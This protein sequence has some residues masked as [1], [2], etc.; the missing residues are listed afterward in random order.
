MSAGPAPCA[1]RPGAS[2]GPFSAARSRPWSAVAPT[3]S[4]TPPSGARRALRAAA[5]S[6]IACA[7]ERPSAT[8]ACT[9]APSGVRRPGQHEHPAARRRRGVERRGERPEAEVGRERDRVG[10]QRR[11]R[12]E[13]GV[14]VPLHRR[15]DVA[16]FDVQQHE[17]RRARERAQQPLQ[18]RDAARPV[19][20]EERRLGLHQRH[21][22]G[23]RV[24]AGVGEPGEPVDVVG[25]PPLLEQRPVRVDPDAQRAQRL[26]GGGEPRPEPAAHR[27]APADDRIDWHSTTPAAVVRCRSRRSSSAC[28]R[29]TARTPSAPRAPPAAT[30]RRSRPPSSPRSPAPRR[31]RPARS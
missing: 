23:Q 8:A 6:T 14:G 26:H 2:T 19:P 9:A 29:V 25:E 12:R 5:S 27:G 13:V 31:P 18:H 3:T 15:A 20:F 1:P 11:A 21:V 17:R 24:D 7:T 16:P 30:A 10:G 28:G 4:P 22:P